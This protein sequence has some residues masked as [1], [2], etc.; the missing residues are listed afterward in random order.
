M[1][2]VHEGAGWNWVMTQ[3]NSLIGIE[4]VLMKLSLS[5]LT[6]ISCIIDGLVQG[7]RE[8]Q[9]EICNCL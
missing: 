1:H 7:K 6:E 2:Y 9:A 5:F 4:G 3:N 8:R